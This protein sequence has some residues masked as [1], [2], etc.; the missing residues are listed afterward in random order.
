[1]ADLNVDVG[2]LEG[3]K[4]DL[5]EIA[6][7][8]A[9]NAARFS[10][11]IALPAGA[12]G[13]IAGL[14]TPLEKFRT[15]HSG[16]LQSDTTAMGDLGTNLS[17]AA[18][19]YRS[20]DQTN[21]TAIASAT[22]TAA[23]NSGAAGVTRFGGLQLP[24]LPDVA[25]DKYVVRQMITSAIARLSP[26][27]EPLSV[28]LGV[29][30]TSEY[31]T[32]LLADWESIEVIGKR[33][34]M[35]GINDY[36]ASQNVVN[37]AGWV[38]S[39]WSGDAAQAFALSAGTLGRTMAARSTDLESVSKI[40][41]QGGIYLER[42]VYNQVADLDSRILETIAYNEMSFPLGAW[43]DLVKDPIPAQL[44]SQIAAGV[45]GLKRAAEARRDA[46]T[47]AV[48]KLSQAL[49]YVPGRNVP[50]Y[51]ATDFE[52]PE[53]I[54]SDPGA[55]RYGIGNTVWWQEGVENRV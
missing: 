32:P 44:K 49:D 38:N 30:P 18:N 52:L 1:M 25:D 5:Q 19:A 15:A 16:A 6:A 23:G 39:G 48:G 17:T 51:S 26:Y 37:G 12:S 35:L 4:L 21:A 8:S 10:P 33:V 36:V 9:S 40:V 46:I 55:K 54:V 13:L 27:D 53:K 22:G 34:G 11:G 31:L 24:G 2:C 42:L 47:A 45:D 14:A 20:T 7:N 3:F 50:A 43:A 29:E 28:A 41:E